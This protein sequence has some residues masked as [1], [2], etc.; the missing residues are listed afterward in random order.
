LPAQGAKDQMHEPGQE[1]GDDHGQSHDEQRL[2]E[3][4]RRSYMILF[5]H[6]AVA[7]A[8]VTPVL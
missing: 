8:R 3:V 2:N 6:T 5:P 1:Q 7:V 4:G